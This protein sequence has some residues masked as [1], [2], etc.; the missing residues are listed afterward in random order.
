MKGSMEKVQQKIKRKSH[1]LIVLGIS[2]CALLLLMLFLAV[3]DKIMIRMEADEIIP[4]G[5]MIDMG[6]Y[7]IHIYTEGNNASAPTMVFLSGSATVAPVYDF[8]PLYRLLSSEYRIAVVE[9]A[10][11]GYSD[12]VDVERDAASLL[13]EVRGAL[14]RAGVNGPYVLVPHSMSGIEAI[15]WAQ[16]Y[17][18]EIAGIVGVDMCVP[19][20][21]DSFDFSP[22]KRIIALGRLAKFLGL[23]RIPGIY[24]VNESALSESEAKQQRLLIHRN[25]VNS[26]YI[27]EGNAIYN[28]A[29]IVKAGEKISCPVLMF[30]SDGTEIGDFWIPTQKQYAEEINARLI[31]FDCGHYIHYYKSDEMAGYIRSFMENLS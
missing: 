4:N 1:V 14:S 20:S 19:Y 22:S 29:Q 23:L 8:K 2:L 27:S 17:P 12:I 13:K 16:N 6:D 24:P 31:F 9:K 10:G 11:Y 18:E 30:C 28:N 25:A 15:Y 5:Q 7:S 21:Y 3:Y 26:V